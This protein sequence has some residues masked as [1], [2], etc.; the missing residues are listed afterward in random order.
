MDLTA[1]N[2]SLLNKIVQMKNEVAKQMD[3]ATQIYQKGLEMM[4]Q[5]NSSSPTA[6]KPTSENLEEFMVTALSAPTKSSVLAKF[7]IK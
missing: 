5:T 1:D 3:E 6:A 4:K 2:R 7:T